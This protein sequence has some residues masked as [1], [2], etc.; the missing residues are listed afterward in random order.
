MRRIAR[1][2]CLR[3]CR[4]RNGRS[5]RRYR[6]SRGCDGSSGGGNDRAGWR[7]RRGRRRLSAGG[8]RQEWTQRVKEGHGSTYTEQEDHQ[9]VAN[10]TAN[11]EER[12]EETGQGA[13]APRFRGSCMTCCC[14]CWIQESERH[15]RPDQRDRYTPDHVVLKARGCHAR[16]KMVGNQDGR[17]ANG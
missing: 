17:D 8:E 13:T 15:Y 7:I 2:G 3:I 16:K 4:G 6:R 5:C 10:R 11:R 12:E 1:R 9:F 14:R